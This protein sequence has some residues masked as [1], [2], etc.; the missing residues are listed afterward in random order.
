MPCFCEESDSSGSSSVAEGFQLN[1]VNSLS[2]KSMSVDLGPSDTVGNVKAKIQQMEG[3]PVFQQQ[4]MLDDTLLDNERTLAHYKIDG[5]S[6][7][8]LVQKFFGVKLRVTMMPAGGAFDLG[9]NGDSLV[10][11]LK[12]A[13]EA[14][15]GI[16]SASQILMSAGQ[17]LQ[18]QRTV[19]DSQI[20]DGQ[21]L[22]LFAFGSH[23]RA[24][25]GGT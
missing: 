3:M 18:N 23:P 9:A 15:T 12:K 14:C 1:V 11:D 7:V 25:Y 5:E 20:Q 2:G 6:M 10:A 16:A 19:A 24:A 4:L 17:P 21:A 22:T 13:I 8:T